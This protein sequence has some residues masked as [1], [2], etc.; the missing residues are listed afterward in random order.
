MN[1]LKSFLIYTLLLPGILFT[2]SCS[3]EGERIPQVVFA[4]STPGD[5]EIKSQLGIPYSAKVDFIR[6]NLILN[7]DNSTINTFALNIV[8][9]EGQPNIT[10]FKGGG[11]KLSFEGEYTVSQ[12]KNDHL[13]G[14]FYHLKSVNLPVEI[15]LL[16]L[17]ENVLHILTAQYQLMIGNGGFSYNLNRK[18]PIPAAPVNVSSLQSLS[19]Y[20]KTDSVLLGV[21]DGRTVCSADLLQL[22]GI[23]R[24]CNRI[25]WQLTLF[26]DPQTHTPATFQI[27]SVYVGVDDNVYT[28][29]GKWEIKQGINSTPIVYL[30]KPEG[31]TRSVALAFLKADDNILFFLDKDLNLMVGNG[32]HSYTLNRSHK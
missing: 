30:L 22:N 26:Q 31:D 15:R 20:P 14:E 10:G 1:Y 32:D 5:E 29:T 16:K 23:K 25:K 28:K 11:I 13:A 21:F 6:W 4:G 18:D 17:N 7:S 2:N 8:Y 3:G 27:K 12:T 9:G 19:S 24:G